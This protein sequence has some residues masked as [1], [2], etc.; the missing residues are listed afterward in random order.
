MGRPYAEA[1]S[2]P[3]PG[4]RQ[5]M[6]TER[7]EEVPEDRKLAEQGN[8][9]AKLFVPDEPDEETDEGSGDEGSEDEGCRAR[10]RGLVR[11]R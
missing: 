10:Q 3:L 5:P 2:D 7:E 6:S 4:Q 1:F 9:D 11:R 8:T